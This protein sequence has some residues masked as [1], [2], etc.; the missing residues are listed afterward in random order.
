M[1][2]IVITIWSRN[3]AAPM[4][5][6]KNSGSQNYK[7]IAGKIDLPNRVVSNSGSTTSGQQVDPDEDP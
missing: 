7:K 3:V 5:A 6:V 4:N 2:V 1:I